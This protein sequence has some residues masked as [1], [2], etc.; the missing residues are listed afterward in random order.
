MNDLY[1]IITA[2]LVASVCALL[3]CFLILRRMAL[4]G[5]AISHSVLPGIV[6]AFMLQG[7]RD[8]LLLMFGAALV[9]LLT[10]YLIQLFTKHGVHG[11]ASIGVV[12]TSLFAAGLV[13][14]SLYTRHIDLDLDCVLFGEI[15]YVPFETTLLFGL[16]ELP[17]AIVGL[18]ATLF[19]VV[20]V[21]ALFYKQFKISS[22]DPALAAALG[23]PV[24]LFHYMLMGMVS[25]STV[26]SFESVGVILVVGMLIVPAATAYLLTE[27]LGAMLAVSVAAGALSA[28]LGY[29]AAYALDASISGSMISAAGLLFVLALLLSP[30]HGVLLRRWRRSGAAQRASTD[31]DGATPQ[32][33]R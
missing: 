11:D 10:V 28:L 23:I 1:V 18:A 15:A 30:R 21:L 31:R 14:V 4:I 2:V 29:G 5:D 25:L 6:V 27:R 13:L 22:F 20:V 3:G 8:S 17:K 19:I 24:G 7:S 32:Q 16:L 9:G 33:A 26:A 12:F